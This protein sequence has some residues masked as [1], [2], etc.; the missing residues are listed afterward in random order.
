MNLKIK[1][2]QVTKE[3]TP[4]QAKEQSEKPVMTPKKEQ[5][6]SKPEEEQLENLNFLNL[7]RI[8]IRLP[9]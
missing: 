3:S 4:E 8:L 5:V 9:F 7:E 2:R 1:V 6:H